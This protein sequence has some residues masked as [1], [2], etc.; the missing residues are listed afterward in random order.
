MIEKYKIQYLVKRVCVPDRI[1]DMPINYC[2]L[3]FVIEGKLNYRI[4]QHTFTVEA[5]DAMFCPEGVT[6]YRENGDEKAVY[7]SVNF[8]C[9]K[10]DIPL[11]PYYLKDVYSHDVGFALE[12]LLEIYLKNSP[13]THR[14]CSSLLEYIICD[15]LEKHTAVNENSH[16]ALM[17]RYIS[18]NWSGAVSL[19]DI[20]SACHLSETYCSALFKKCTGVTVSDYVMNIRLKRAEEMLRFSNETVAEIASKTGFCDIYYFSRAFK[21]NKGMSPLQYRKLK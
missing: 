13:Y 20:A 7:V 21:K 16:V 14:K 5:G 19:S 2:D 11:L 6:R 9:E 1:F 10:E 8:R 12:K 17:K 4:G 3:T 18:N 15:I